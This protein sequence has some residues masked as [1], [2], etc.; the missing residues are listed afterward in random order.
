MSQNSDCDDGK[1]IDVAPKK[2]YAQMLLLGNRPIVSSRE[3]NALG[4]MVDRTTNDLKGLL[5]GLSLAK[6]TLNDNTA[7]K[8]RKAS[9]KTACERTQ[10]LSDPLLNPPPTPPLSNKH[11]RACSITS[12][13]SPASTKP[14]EEEVSTA[15][16]NSDSYNTCTLA[17]HTPHATWYAQ[18][19]AQVERFFKLNKAKTRF[20][21]RKNLYA[22]DDLWGGAMWFHAHPEDLWDRKA[23]AEAGWS[24]MVADERVKEIEDLYAATGFYDE[25]GYEGVWEYASLNA[26]AKLVGFAQ[27]RQEDLFDDVWVVGDGKWEEGSGSEPDV[28]PRNEVI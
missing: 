7:T 27:A 5:S 16:H 20:Q 24:S 28:G 23:K 25:P 21:R 26:R 19:I 18:R 4:Q 1:H 2:T 22:I 13:A 14:T 3:P 12:T 8:S 9:T 17:S 11:S 6:D 10:T 15:H